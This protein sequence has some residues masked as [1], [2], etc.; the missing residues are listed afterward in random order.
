MVYA[1]LQHVLGLRV[2]SAQVCAQR[3]AAL[4][5]RPNLLPQPQAEVD[6]QGIPA[7]ES[8]LY[9]ATK[10]GNLVSDPHFDVETHAR[11]CLLS[12]SCVC[13]L[14]RGALAGEKLA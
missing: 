13:T 9:I 4:T 6:K 11:C 1:L 10:N 3:C 8:A 14:T 12:T 5:W 7:G 2:A